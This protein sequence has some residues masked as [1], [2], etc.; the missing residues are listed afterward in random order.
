MIRNLN[1][2]LLSKLSRISSGKLVVEVDGLRFFAIISV[3]FLHI[4][5]T[6][7]NKHS[8]LVLYEDNFLSN[9]L[10]GG[11][12]GVQLFIAISG[13]ILAKPFADAIL[14]GKKPVSYSLYIK[15][16]LLRLEPPFILALSLRLL[17]LLFLT[18]ESG[19]FLNYLSSLFYSHTLIYEQPSLILGAAW[20]LEVEFQFYLVAPFLAKLYFSTGVIARRCAACFIILLGCLM[21]NRLGVR[22]SLSFFGQV[23]YF[24][25][26]FIVLDC[27]ERVKVQRS[28]IVDLIGLFGVCYLTLHT[29]MFQLYGPV[30][31]LLSVLSILCIFVAAIWGSAF[32]YIT[33]IRWFAALGGMCYTIYL[34]HGTMISLFM[35]RFTARFN[36]GDGYALNLLIQLIVVGGFIFLCSPIL[37]LILERPFMRRDWPQRFFG[38]FRKNR[39]SSNL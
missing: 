39:K 27:Y 5:S 34:F 19:L 25:I 13:F 15:K 14:S 32:N 20:T 16:R 21:A 24:M 35:N 26:G 17:L 31:E 8:E 7:K 23:Q 36:L 18:S 12:V 11:G 2:F 6:Y 4:S 29:H 1:E 10:A 30:D 33:S 22:L 28:V 3:V 9:A 38:V 37:F